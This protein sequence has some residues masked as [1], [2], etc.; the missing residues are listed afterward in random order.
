MLSLDQ[1]GKSDLIED[2][3]EVFFLF[4]AVI[5]IIDDIKDLE[6]YLNIDHYSYI[7]LV[8]ENLL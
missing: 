8:Y 4:G 6:E 3:F 2:Y 1:L 5:Q 7:T